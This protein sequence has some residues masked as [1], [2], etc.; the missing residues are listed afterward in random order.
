MDNLT[1]EEIIDDM[2]LYHFNDLPDYISR[3]NDKICNI[4]KDEIKAWADAYTTLDSKLYH[5]FET[6]TK[7][8]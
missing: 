4:F 1:K 5:F 3:M 8:D 6:Q 2:K 7:D